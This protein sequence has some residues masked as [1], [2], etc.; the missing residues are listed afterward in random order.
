MRCPNQVDT[1]RELLH[2]LGY[3]CACSSTSLQSLS[4]PQYAHQVKMHFQILARVFGAWWGVCDM[5]H[6]AVM[7]AEGR[8]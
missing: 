7:P 1:T 4:K 6:L 2:S 5:G 3:S 8:T